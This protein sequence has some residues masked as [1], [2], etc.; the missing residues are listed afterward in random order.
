VIAAEGFS[1]T[2][3]TRSIAMMKAAMPAGTNKVSQRRKAVIRTAGGIMS[4]ASAYRRINP[5]TPSV[6]RL[7]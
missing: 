5:V 2:K 4:S 3:I 1:A 6:Q 7:V